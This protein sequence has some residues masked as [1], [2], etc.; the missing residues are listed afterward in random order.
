MKKHLLLGLSLL[1]ACLAGCSTSVNSGSTIVY[2]SHRYYA[3]NSCTKHIDCE[4]CVGLATEEE[5]ATC[6]KS[7]AFNPLERVEDQIRMKV[8]EGWKVIDYQALAL[9]CV[10]S[11][12]EDAISGYDGYTGLY[13][14]IHYIVTY[15][16]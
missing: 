12:H 13:G 11:N 7:T 15:K 1:P 10:N 2:C 8:S 5:K 3:G 9:P 14:H 4:T 6:A 16:R